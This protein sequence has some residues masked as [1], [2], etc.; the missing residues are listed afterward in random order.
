MAQNKV[1]RPDFL[2]I[3]AALIDA[4]GD[5]KAAAKATGWGESSVRKVKRAGTWPKYQQATEARRA[6][7]KLAQQTDE[8]LANHELHAKQLKIDRLERE[9][10]HA[11]EVA[12]ITAKAKKRRSFFGRLFRKNA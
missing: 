5:V 4:Q 1:T 7:R 6:H 10:T 9:L 12:D 8:N 2:K 3:K 11:R